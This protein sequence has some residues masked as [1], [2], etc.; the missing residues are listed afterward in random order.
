MGR[1]Q[2]IRKTRGEAAV[3]ASKR[4]ACSIYLIS[5]RAKCG[6]RHH[7]CEEH[8][9]WLAEGPEPRARLYISTMLAK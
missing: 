6:E 8:A 9:S 2:A 7:D 3:C 1:V 5:D 4:S